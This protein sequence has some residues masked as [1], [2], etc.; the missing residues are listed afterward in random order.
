MYHYHGINTGVG[1]NK[2]SILITGTGVARFHHWLCHHT[3]VSELIL[4][5]NLFDLGSMIS[6]EMLRW[7]RGCTLH[8]RLTSPCR[9]WNTVPGLMERDSIVSQ[10]S[11]Q[12][13]TP[14]TSRSF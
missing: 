8:R 1:A 5:T 9:S 10:I 3:D 7:G 13:C 6:S 4:S 14:D 12:P 11:A 2:Y